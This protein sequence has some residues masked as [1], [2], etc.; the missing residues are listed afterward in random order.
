MLHLEQAI[1]ANIE[2]IVSV[3]VKQAVSSEFKKI[4]KT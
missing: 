4:K 1:V 2:N 3:S